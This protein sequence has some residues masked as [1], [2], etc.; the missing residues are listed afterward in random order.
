MSPLVPH[1]LASHRQLIQYSRGK[2]RVRRSASLGA[3]F[4]HGRQQPIGIA[5]LA[6][7][8]EHF[9]QRSGK[10]AMA[11]GFVSRHVSA[12]G[13]LVRANASYKSFVPLEVALD[14]EE[15]KRRLRAQDRSEDSDPQDPGNR[16]VNFR[17]GQ[18][19]FSVLWRFS[20]R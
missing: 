2:L 16:A 12:D 4:V 3:P 13:T 5:L 10:Q 8:H 6:T 1:A 18:M 15:Y 19:C 20:G 11:A 14:P 7:L 9:R 17:R